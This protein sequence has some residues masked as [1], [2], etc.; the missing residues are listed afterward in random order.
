VITGGNVGGSTTITGTGIGAPDCTPGPIQV[1][2]C[3]PDKICHNSDD[4]EL[5]VVSASYDNGHFTIVLVDPLVPGDI[6]FVTDG[7]HDPVISVSA[8]VK[9]PAPVPV[10]SRD[11]IVVLVAALGLLGLLGLTRLRLRQQLR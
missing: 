6:I 1:F 4:F 5:A 7:C 11:L 9:F 10:M 2:D 3:G 8:L